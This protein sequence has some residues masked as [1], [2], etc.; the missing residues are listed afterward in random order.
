MPL[1]R[2]KPKFAYS[3]LTIVLSNPS[4]LDI[5]NKRL[6]SGSGGQMLDEHCLRTEF[7]SMQCDVRLADE[8]DAILPGTKC[9]LLL[10][11]Y[12]AHKFLPETSNQSIEMIRGGLYEHKGIPTICSFLPQDARDLKNYEKTHNQLSHDYSPDD[13]VSENDEDEGD[14]KAFGKTKRANYCFWLRADIKK[15]KSI[16]NNKLDKLQVGSKSGTIQYITNPSATVAINALTETKGQ[17]LYFDIETDYEQQNLQC[18]AFSFDGQTIYSIPILDNNY[19]LA[20]GTTTYSILKALAIAIRDNTLVAHNGAAFDFFVLAHK[21]KIAI[22]KT[23]DTMIAMHR[24]FPDIEKS[25][26]HCVSYWTSLKFHKAED[27]EGYFTHQQMMDRLKYCAKDVYTM[28]LVKQAIDSYA[29]TIPGLQRSIDDAMNCIKPYLI[30]TLQ[31]IRVDEKKVNIMC[32][33]NDRLMMQYNRM[34]EILIGPVGLAQIREGKKCSLFPGSPKQCMKYFY[35]LLGYSVMKNP[36]T[37]EPSLGKKQLYQLALKE[38]NP[39]ITLICIYRAVQKET[40][41]LRFKPWIGNYALHKIHSEGA[42][43]AYDRIDSNFTT[44]MVQKEETQM[45]EETN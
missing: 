38:N 7:N 15:C 29:K 35:D 12:A 33:E 26:G 1:L 8:A 37:G 28:F 25:L 45:A 9:L 20:Y 3:G 34:I 23:Y 44:S 43:A 40:S 6:L 18:F 42:E 5:D 24:C 13:S 14:V 30:A 16:I 11:E 39:V 4:R 17:H 10:G 2:S 41:R 22:G 19:H 27:S 21:Y 31:G 32:A 36:K